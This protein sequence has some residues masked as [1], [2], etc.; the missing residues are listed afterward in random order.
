MKSCGSHAVR[1]V[2]AMRPVRALSFDLDGTLLDDSSRWHQ[3]IVDTCEKVAAS[4]PG[5]EAARLVEAN[6]EVWEDYFPQ[7]EEK[8][9]LG[10]L[11][12]ASLSLEAWR[13]TL[14][15]CG[16][17]D[18]FVTQLAWQTF[19]QFEREAQRLFD[20]VPELFN[21]VRSTRLLI[22]LVTNGASDTQRGKLRALGIEDWFDVVVI[23][24]E[25]GT[26][27]PD[28]AIFNVA[29]DKLAVERENLWHVGDS[30]P[31]DVAG[32][33]A[34]SVTSVWLN[35]SGRARREGEPGPDFEIRSLSSLMPLLT[36]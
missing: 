28:P 5:L 1:Y 20:D 23:S 12:G 36:G 13:R 22:A 33:N 35:R 18:E 8:W 15:A 31:I 9:A 16:C 25:I 14:L 2:R 19:R 32:A 3:S 4:Q 29:L 21:T 6:V 10:A 26:M 34:A 11:D 27:K 24:G 17:D 7:V 30:L